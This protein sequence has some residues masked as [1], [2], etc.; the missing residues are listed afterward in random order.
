MRSAGARP[1]LTAYAFD[2][3]ALMPDKM[4]KDH[5]LSWSRPGD[6]VFDPMA[7]AAT[8]CKMA[9]LNNRRY[10]GFEIHEPYFLLAQRRMRDAHANYRHELD[11]WLIGA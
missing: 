4:A 11:A 1:Q 8:T 9:L 6:L 10:L 7:G 2:H 3:P 5:I